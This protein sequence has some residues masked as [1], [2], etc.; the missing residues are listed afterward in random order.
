MKLRC[1][2]P[3]LVTAFLVAS[4]SPL[5]VAAAVTFA[6]DFNA[7]ASGLWGNEVGAWVTTGGTYGATFVPPNDFPSAH[8]SLPFVL[9]DFTVQFDANDIKDGGIWLRSS[10]AGATAVGRVG[11][12][13]VTGGRGGTGTGLYWHIVP[14]GSSYGSILNEATGLFTSGVSD[15]TIR[16]VV[17]GDTY[18]AYVGNAVTPATVLVTNTF[19][20]GQVALVDSGPGVESFDNFQ[21]AAVPEPATLALMISGLAVLCAHTKKRIVS[22]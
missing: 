5:A 14:N 15:A 21:L 11:V 12:M 13:L 10:A 6:D 8:S 20:S 19:A 7:G 4:I 17:A 3:S 2:V 9:S 22:K 1:F 16:V 18:S